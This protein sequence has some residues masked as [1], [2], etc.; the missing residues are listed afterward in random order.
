[1]GKTRAYKHRLDKYYHLAHAVGYRSRAAFKLIQLNQ[2]YDFLTNATCCLDLCAAPG[3]WSQVAAK[4]M[5]AGSTIIAIDLAPIKPIPHVITLQSDITSPK[6]HAKV[7]KI[8]QGNRCDVVLNDGAPNVGAAWITDSTNQLD[9]CLASVKFA[10]IFLKKGGSFVTKV[11][12]SEH[13][14]SLLWVLNQFFEQVIPTKPKASRDTSAE[15]FIVCLHFKAPTMVDPRMLDPQYVFTDIDELT[16]KPLPNQES[17]ETKTAM[18]YT[19]YK[20]CDFLKTENPLDILNAVNELIFDDSPLSVAA[21]SHPNTNNEIKTL[22]KDLKVVG[23]ADKKIL[24]KWRK[25]M[26][27][28]LINSSNDNDNNNANEDEE[29]GSDEEIQN[30]LNELKQKKRHQEKVEKRRREKMKTQLIKRLQKNLAAPSA[31]ADMLDPEIRFGKMY[32]PVIPEEDLSHLTHEEMVERNIEYLENLDK[33]N[34]VIKGPENT[35]GE[36]MGPVPKLKNF[37]ILSE[38]K[39]KPS[40][41]DENEEEEDESKDAKSST[42]SKEDQEA[43]KKVNQWF[44]HP[45]FEDSSDDDD[46]EDQ[47]TA[48]EAIKEDLDAKKAKAA[49]LKQKLQAKQEKQQL[50]NDINV[51]DNE[52]YDTES[53]SEELYGQSLK[54]F[55]ALAYK[56]SREIL[57]SKHRRDEMINDSFNRYMHDDGPSVPSWFAA[58]EANYNRPMIPI[59]KQEVAEWRQRM[60][61]IN[62]VETKRVIEARARKKAKA[63]QRLKSAQEKADEIAEKEG[64]DERSKLRMMEQIA[65]KGMAALKQKERVVF[66]RKRDNGS[67]SIPKGKGKVR[68]V[69]ARGKKDLRAE[70]YAAKRPSNVVKKKKSKY[71]HRR[72]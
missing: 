1:M 18:D 63:L 24:L 20:V 66:V 12:R 45:L 34:G 4:Y 44:S 41:K 16:K 32:T 38:E 40:F 26:R 56:A 48:K 7:R 67:P 61:S 2:Q 23:L 59:T 49:E 47:K 39:P 62:E 60:R 30:A 57:T 43:E 36:I 42:K 17:I 58:E 46:E 28:A 13:Y 50:T 51:E 68:L 19:S 54:D 14:N 25:Q 31:N 29:I 5:P 15:L 27:A 69:D 21:F 22:C 8:M 55:D 35:D 33:E 3:G 6:T 11:F 64:L 9:L 52:E 37:K 65:A 53:D 10:T 71:I 72:K 70:K